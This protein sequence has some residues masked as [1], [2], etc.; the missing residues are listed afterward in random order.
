MA[1]DSPQASAQTLRALDAVNFLMADVLTGIGP[2]LAIYL[3]A[4]LHWGPAEIGVA[5]SVGGFAAIVA[6]TP[7]GA[8]VD[9]LRHKREA[10]AVGAALV[11]LGCI[12]MAALQSFAGIV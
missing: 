1:K 8:V 9:R 3:S 5:M 6:Q 4:S 12:V 11:G 2:F 7:M 10:M